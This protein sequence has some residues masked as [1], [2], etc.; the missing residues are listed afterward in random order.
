MAEAFLWSIPVR[1]NIAADVVDRHAGSGKLA[2]IEVDA[3]GKPVE[4][5]FAA[6]AR[7]SNRLANLLLAQGLLRGDRVAILLPQRHETAVAHIAVYKA[8]LVAVPL[9]NLFLEEA[10]E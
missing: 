4:F 9:F 3:S 8:A 2:L 6:I 10:L 1:F 5:D 7:L